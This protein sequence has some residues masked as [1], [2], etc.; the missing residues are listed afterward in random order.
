MQGVGHIPSLILEY[1]CDV[2]YHGPGSD[3]HLPTTTLLH[4]VEHNPRHHA[5]KFRVTYS[6]YVLR[7]R[8]NSNR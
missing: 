7:Q 1:V 3:N 5:Y 8:E 4:G 2:Q 6:Y